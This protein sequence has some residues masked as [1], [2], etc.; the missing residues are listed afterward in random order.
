MNSLLTVII[1]VYRVSD[2]I[3]RCIESIVGQRYDNMEIIL[4][5]DGS[6]DES[7]EICDRWAERDSRIA[8]IHKANGGLSDAR[9]AG[10]DIARGE[11]VTFVDSDDYIGPDTYGELM[12]IITEHPEYD[13]L[14]YP[15]Y[16]FFGSDK[17]Q[18]LTFG[19]N[20]FNDTTDYWMTAQAYTHAYAWNKIYRHRLF[21]GIRFPAGRVFEDID[22]LPRLLGQARTVATTGKG[23]Y[24]YCSNDSGITARA[25]GN[26]LRMLLDSHLKVIDR[27]RKHPLFHRYYMHVVNI[28]ICEYERTGDKPLLKHERVK[29]LDGLDIKSKLKATAINIFGIKGL[30]ILIKYINKMAKLH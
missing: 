21:D 26:D 12:S 10:L 1:P 3:D 30:C 22:T 8:V 20:T 29:R 27:Y 18:L 24:Y 14:E 9:N 11:Y 25:N 23:I 13:I 7:P 17:Q 16:R 4:V 5:D 15:V 2:T 19:D 28:Q 6:P